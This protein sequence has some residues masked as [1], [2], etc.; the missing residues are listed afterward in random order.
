VRNSRVWQD[1]T[2]I[3]IVEAVFQ[4]HAPLAVWRWSDETMPF[5]EADDGHTMVLFANS[6]E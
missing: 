2:V 6:V 4:E 5:M 1:K 3:E